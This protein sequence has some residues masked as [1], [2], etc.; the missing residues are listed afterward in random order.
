MNFATTWGRIHILVFEYDSMQFLFSIRGPRLGSDDARARG[1]AV[2]SPSITKLLLGL[3]C[4]HWLVHPLQKG[5]HDHLRWCKD[6]K[7]N[8]EGISL[9]TKGDRAPTCSTN[10]VWQ[11]S[12]VS[13]MAFSGKAWNNN[14]RSLERLSRLGNGDIG[15]LKSKARHQRDFS[16]LAPTRDETSHPLCFLAE[17]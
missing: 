7:N 3:C 4:P 10:E 5:Y 13:E 17:M 1:T 2:A 15:S 11:W 12:R 16:C 9:T 14:E 8:N 6:G